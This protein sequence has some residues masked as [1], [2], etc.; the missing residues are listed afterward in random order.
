VLDE[1]PDGLDAGGA[2]EL[3]ELRQLVV[4]IDALSEHGEDEPA[5]GLE[6]RRGIRTSRR[7]ALP[8]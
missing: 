2:G 7:H 4:R 1:A 6:T 8:L 5:L 3:L